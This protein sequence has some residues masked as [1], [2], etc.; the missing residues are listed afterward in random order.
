M[1]FIEKELSMKQTCFFHRATFYVHRVGRVVLRFTHFTLQ[2]YSVM[3]FF[4]L[5]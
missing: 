1:R 3:N 5:K 2:K 4:R